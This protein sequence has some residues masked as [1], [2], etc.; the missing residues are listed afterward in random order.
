MCGA[1]SDCSELGGHNRGAWTSSQAVTE[2]QRGRSRQVSLAGLAFPCGSF[3]A[4]RCSLEPGACVPEPFLPTLA[5]VCARTTGQESRC[6]SKAIAPTRASPERVSDRRAAWWGRSVP[7][8]PSGAH[9]RVGRQLRAFSSDPV[10]GD[11]SQQHSRPPDL[12]EATALPSPRMA[13][14]WPLLR[15]AP[16]GWA[17]PGTKPASNTLRSDSGGGRAE[18]RRM[19]S[20]PG[21]RR[22]LP[23]EATR[24]P[25]RRPLGTPGGCL[26]ACWAMLAFLPWPWP[27]SAHIL[28]FFFRLGGNSGN[29][30][31]SPGCAPRPV[32]ALPGLNPQSVKPGA[33]LRAEL[34][35]ACD[36]ASGASGGVLPGLPLVPP[37]LSPTP[38]LHPSLVSAGSGEAPPVEYAGACL[39]WGVTAG[40]PGRPRL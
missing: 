21:Q 32:G 27:P 17:L 9:L 13:G 2:R 11:V 6:T 15:P 1:C 25:H 36:L 22:C 30:T 12:Q 31:G 23:S 10:S 14:C 39:S 38:A 24:G 33:W 4:V 35:V 34:G 8:L 19:R 7:A 5:S 40:G 3:T 16:R 18:G 29:R 28:R 20:G 26:R 37:A